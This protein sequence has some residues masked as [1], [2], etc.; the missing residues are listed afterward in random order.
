M[1]Q[2]AMLASALLM[3]SLAV[4]V[5]VWALQR[6]IRSR[7]HNY[8]ETP[9]AI[10]RSSATLIE[11]FPTP[12]QLSIPGVTKTKLSRVRYA[13]RAGQ[14]PSTLVLEGQVTCRNQGKKPI[15]AIGLTIVLLDAFYQPVQ[16]AS[17]PEP[18]FSHQVMLSIAAGSE[19]TIPWSYDA[20]SADVQ[21]VAV[22][23][24]RVRFAD[25][26]VWAAPPEELID[27]F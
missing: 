19:T 5:S 21:E 26:T 7:A 25:G 1:P 8:P 9:V 6:S 15:E 24:T 16:P 23:V 27:I 18:Y 22:I 14:L 13:N 10:K 11:T 4:S 2:Q 12:T 20:V 17:H 3:L